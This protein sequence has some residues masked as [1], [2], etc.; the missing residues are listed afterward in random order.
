[1]FIWSW[2]EVT[3]MC[4]L[5][6]NIRH[7]DFY[8]SDWRPPKSIPRGWDFEGVCFKHDTKEDPGSGTSAMADFEAWGSTSDKVVNQADKAV[9][10]LGLTWSALGHALQ[11]DNV[12][13]DCSTGCRKGGWFLRTSRFLSSLPW[14][15]CQVTTL[16]LSSFFISSSSNKSVLFEEYSFHFTCLKPS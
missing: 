5:L 15:F 9:L 12:V 8:C 7:P 11:L 14:S 6:A 4:E 16:T 10:L 13:P 2:A 1:M 3:T